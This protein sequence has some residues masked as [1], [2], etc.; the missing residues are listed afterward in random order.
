MDGIFDDN[1][2]NLGF[3][4]KVTNNTDYWF[5]LIPFNIKSRGTCPLLVKLASKLSLARPSSGSRYTLFYWNSYIAPLLTIR[6]K[7]WWLLPTLNKGFGFTSLKS[8]NLRI[9][10]I[11]TM[12][13]IFNMKLFITYD[14]LHWKTYGYEI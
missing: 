9:Q 7:W 6:E 2:E 14:I 5:I 3:L 8:L 4:Y 1:F 10:L 11:Y 12:T 13:M